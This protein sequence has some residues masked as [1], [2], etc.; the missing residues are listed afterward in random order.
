[1]KCGSYAI[2]MDSPLQIIYMITPE[3]N[4]FIDL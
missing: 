3:L 2:G 4:A 1:M